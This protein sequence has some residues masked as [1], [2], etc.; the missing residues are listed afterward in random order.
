MNT[1]SIDGILS[2]LRNKGKANIEKSMFGFLGYETH[3][4]PC[5]NYIICEEAKREIEDAFGNVIKKI[6]PYA[7]LEG[8]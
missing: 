5:K 6:S 2:E 1:S 4:S 7:I 8:K 3:L